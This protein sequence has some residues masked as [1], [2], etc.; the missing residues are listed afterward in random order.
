MGLKLLPPNY[1]EWLPVRKAHLKEDLQKSEYTDDLFKQYK[2]HLGI[3]RYKVLI[4]GQ[5]LVV[6][7]EVKA[8]LKFNQF[9]LITPV[10]PLYKFSRL[11]KMDWLVKKI[12]LPADYTD[13]IKKLDVVVR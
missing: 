9:S 10:L 8:L 6:P 13:E 11:V 5:K 7:D 1:I 2:K 4:E 12:L 3:M